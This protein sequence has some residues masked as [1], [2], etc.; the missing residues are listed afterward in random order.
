MATFGTAKISNNAGQDGSV[1]KKN[2]GS[3]ENKGENSNDNDDNDESLMLRSWIH[4][5]RWVIRA[6]GFAQDDKF[7][8]R[9]IASASSFKQKQNNSGGTEVLEQC[10]SENV[11]MER[12][13]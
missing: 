11:T 5:V 12:L 2:G 4:E 3:V 8:Q 6:E 7:P 9:S 1:T 10:D 13:A